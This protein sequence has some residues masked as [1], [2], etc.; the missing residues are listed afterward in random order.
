MSVSRAVMVNTMGWPQ[1]AV[2]G[3]EA[4]QELSL[5][6]LYP[7]CLLLLVAHS[8]PPAIP[9]FAELCLPQG[10]DTCSLSRE[11]PVHSICGLPAFR[12]PLG[13]HLRDSVPKCAASNSIPS[14]AII[15]SPASCSFVP[16]STH[17][18]DA[19]MCAASCLLSVFL[20]P[21]CEGSEPGACLTHPF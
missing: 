19:I 1:E 6:L 8:R 5:K 17:H 14:P 4:V 3:L 2:C 20:T 13:C 12:P 15:S 10:P 7:Q 21:D 18:P 9:C 11:Q 16:P